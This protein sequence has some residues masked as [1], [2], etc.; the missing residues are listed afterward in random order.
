VVQEGVTRRTFLQTSSFAV[1]LAA[2]ALPAAAQENAN[3]LGIGSSSYG[4]RFGHERRN[5][6]A[7]PL[8]DPLHFLEYCRSIG[9]GGIQTGLGTLDSSAQRKLRH[10]AERHGMFVE[11]S[12]RLPGEKSGLSDFKEAVRIAK[13]AGAG[14]IRSVMLSGRRYETFDSFKDFEAFAERSWTSLTLAEPILRNN[15]MY[16]A[17]ENHKDWRISDMLALLKRM[18]SEFVGVCVD[19]GNNIALL[20]DPLA[21]VQ[22]FAPYAKSVHLKDMGVEEYDEGFLLSEVPL[23]E[24]YLDMP[25]IVNI[26]RAAHPG[27]RFSLEMITRDPL[28]IPCLTEGYWATFPE[29]P[30]A[31]L[32]RTLVAVQKNKSARPLP[33]VSHL[34]IE[35]RLKI[36][37]DNVRKCLA[38]ARDHLNL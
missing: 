11:A 8:S 9:A 37:D 19:T 36:E 32:A 20:D 28:K 10:T 24:G 18:S 2:G 13:N 21:L 22:A 7:Q 12:L 16:L 6:P 25:R 1:S 34:S 29:L 4:I 17:L 27:L 30:G 33:R 3:R 38:Y 35:E 14:V 5:R 15:R 31:D 26:L 23:G